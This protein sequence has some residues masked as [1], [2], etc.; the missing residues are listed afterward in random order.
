M[1]E[2]ITRL[3]SSLKVKEYPI[4]IEKA[5]IILDSFKRH[6]GEPAILRRAM[7]T[8]D[9][10]D[11]RTIFIEEDELIVGNVA[12]KPMGME[13]GSQTPAWA[14]EDI[15]ELRKQ[16]LS[17][18]VEDEAILRSMDEYWL[19]KGRT[20]EERQGQFYDDERLW[21]FIQSGILCPP[22]KISLMDGVMGQPELGGGWES[23]TA[24]SWWTMP[25]YSIKVSGR[26]PA[27]HEKN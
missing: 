21:P 12:S 26:S 14:H 24:W 4:C 7:A 17:L 5:Q 20:V 19:G 9:Y 16:G 1:N 3:M 27:K 2:R 8:A 15:E 6:E 18:S 10:L 23:A 22:G 11:K 13:V 25:K